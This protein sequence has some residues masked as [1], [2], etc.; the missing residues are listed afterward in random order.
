MTADVSETIRNVRLRYAATDC[1]NLSR[2][3]SAAHAFTLATQARDLGLAILVERDREQ[4]RDAA[5]PDLHSVR[6]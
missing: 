6:V 5:A 1:F 4:G 2:D 3:L